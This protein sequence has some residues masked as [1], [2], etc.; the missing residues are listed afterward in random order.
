MVSCGKQARCRV[1]N[2]F[3]FGHRVLVLVSPQHLVVYIP[4]QVT[5]FVHTTLQEERE[6][7]PLAAALAG[8]AIP[9]RT[10]SETP[11]ENRTA[12]GIS[13]IENRTVPGTGLPGVLRLSERA[14]DAIARVA[15]LSYPPEADVSPG[16]LLLLYFSRPRV[17]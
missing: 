15:L 11:S 4:A 12:S 1:Y 14:V 6:A 2:Q 9:N 3:V 10:A 16:L 5:I 8:L 13:V 17:E 7:I